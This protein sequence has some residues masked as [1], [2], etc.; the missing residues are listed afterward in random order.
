M[1]FTRLWPL[2]F[3]IAIPV[4]ILLYMLKKQNQ[5]KV[6]S[7]IFLW[8]EIYETTYADKPWQ[9][10]KNHILLCLQ[11][12]AI[13]LLVLAL[14]TPHAPWGQSYYKNVI[15]VVDDSAS[16]Q[17]TYQD[18]TR[19]EAA[20]A[21]MKDYIEAA[22]EDT[23]GYL[24]TAGSSATLTLAGSS[25]KQT[26]LSAIR[27]I[28]PTYSTAHI[29]ESVQM[30]KALGE[31]LKETYEIVVLTDS[32]VEV[33][34]EVGRY[35]YFGEAG[36]NSAIALMS[37]QQTEQGIT[38]LMQVMNKGN[39]PYTGDVSL[40]GCR[41]GLGTEELLDVQEISLKQGESSTLHFDLTTS[42]E[43]NMNF[44][45]LKGELS[46]DDVLK[47]DNTYYY[48]P[49]ASKGRKIL[50]VTQGNVF[51]EKALMTL[52]NCEV[53][54]TNDITLIESE[55]NYDLYV[56]DGQTVTSLPKVGNILLVNSEIGSVE[57]TNVLL[58]ELQA[59]EQAD[60]ISQSDVTEYHVQ[61]VQGVKEN[62]PDYL[63]ALNF[64]AS[65]TKGYKLPYWGK[66]LLQTSDNTVGF[67]G[68]QNG[69]KVGVLGLDLWS[70]D[71]VL[72]T[73]FPL[74][75]QYIGDELLD[76]A[77][78]SQY[79]FTSDERIT[80]RQNDLAEELKVKTL[81]GHDVLLDNNQFTSSNYL[82]VYQV[83][84]LDKS[85]NSL[86]STLLAVNYPA[87][88]ES[89]LQ[90]DLSGEEVLGQ[91]GSLKGNKNLTPYFITLLLGIVLVEWYFYRKGY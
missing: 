39:K 60:V 22:G 81:E 70:S 52:E 42:Q 18:T 43:D 82:G 47:E 33:G 44:S 7:S 6:V 4:L 38:V 31:S 83:E 72:T 69:Q 23:K 59:L 57:T 88:T 5:P 10:F 77:R 75:I 1:Q 55:E 65:K 80:L 19:M 54:K 29:E 79:N 20:K 49:N 48:V 2:G 11:I 41:E 26:L 34:L 84:V 28:E 36:L 13:I 8:Q 21:W 24:I 66:S 3:L 15:F 45:Y 89:N 63:S 78:V 86:A 14:M 40:Y 71:F 56:L 9:K 90:E 73:D 37:H 30:A 25:Q 17:A 53:Y 16:M 58:K 76:T 62:L 12:L 51:L 27:Q 64:V 91:A 35:V 85:K 61:R 32:K 74:L 68:D 87:G 46:T 67:I 50:L